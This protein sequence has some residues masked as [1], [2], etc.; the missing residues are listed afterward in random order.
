MGQKGTWAEAW[1]GDIRGLC[2]LVVLPMG[3]F[4]TS[5]N[6]EGEQG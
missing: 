2:L 1:E 6:T 5:G 4:Q 3:H